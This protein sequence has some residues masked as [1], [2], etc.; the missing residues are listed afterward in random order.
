MVLGFNKERNMK[1]KCLFAMMAAALT[2]AAVAQDPAP[3]KAHQVPAGALDPIVRAALNP[4]VSKKIGLT[5][6][7]QA[8]LRAVAGDKDVLKTLQE[9]VRKGMSRQAELVAAEK[10]DEA[11][12]MAALDDVFAARKEVAKHQMKRLIA[13]KSILTPDQIKQATEAFRS[14][15][16]TKKVKSGE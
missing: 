8:K 9:K 16:R 14:L 7:Q 13:V 12:V 4:K 3:D 15:K 11:A 5:E 2:L 10:I 6:E 1:M